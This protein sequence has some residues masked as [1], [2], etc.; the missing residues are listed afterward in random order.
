MMDIRIFPPSWGKSCVSACRL[1]LRARG[2]FPYGRFL[3]HRAVSITSSVLVPLWG[4]VGRG[5]GEG[6]YADVIVPGLL[7]TNGSLWNSIFIV[8]ME[9]G[10]HAWRSDVGSTAALMGKEMSVFWQ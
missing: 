5:E 8:R 9:S 3:L 2:S 4:V 10:L 1:D 6:T 7:L